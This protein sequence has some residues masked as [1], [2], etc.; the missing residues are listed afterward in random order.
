M[1]DEHHCVVMSFL[2][3]DQLFVVFAFV[4]IANVKC[5]IMILMILT[6]DQDEGVDEW[7]NLV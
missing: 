7:S 1:P 5:M 2:L 6:F 4:M 3:L